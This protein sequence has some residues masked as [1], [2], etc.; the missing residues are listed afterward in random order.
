MLPAIPVSFSDERPVKVGQASIRYNP[1]REIFTNAS[2]FI[3]GYDYTLNPY[4][5]CSFGCS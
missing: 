1:A 2:G 4:S 3:D 5:G